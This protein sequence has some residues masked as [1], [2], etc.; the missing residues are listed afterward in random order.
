[1]KY[2]P[3]ETKIEHSK[4]LKL[5]NLEV[6]LIR[7]IRRIE[8]QDY[9]SLVRK[10]WNHYLN[11][12]EKYKLDT[13]FVTSGGHFD[14]VKY[15]PIGMNIVKSKL[16][17]LSSREVE[18]IRMVRKIEGDEYQPLVRKMWNHYLNEMEKYK[19]DTSFVKSERYTQKSSLTDQK[20]QKS[21]VE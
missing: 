18:L 7:M 5:I 16:L 11:E 13:S 3:I 21:S 15:H 8:G 1:M 9:Q 14:K 19:L 20:V 6:E 10:M 17:N 2:H 4:L 12:M